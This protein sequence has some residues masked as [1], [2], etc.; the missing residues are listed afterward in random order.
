MTKITEHIQKQ[1]M[2]ALI[3]LFQLDC[4]MFGDQI[5][6]LVSGDFG[7]TAHQVTFG[8]IKYYP[9]PI[10]ADGF[11]LAGQGTL[12]KP[13]FV[14]ANVGNIFTSMVLANRGLIGAELTRIRTF[15]KFLDNGADPDPTATLASDV[16]RLTRKV[17]HT[18][19][20]IQWELSAAMDQAG[21]ELPGR[22]VARDYCDHVYRSWNTAAGAFDYS[23]CTC[24]YVG[25]SYFDEYDNPTTADKDVCGKRLSSCKLRFGATAEL[26][27]RGFPGVATVK[28][29]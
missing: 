18:R 26:P 16:Y 24:P 8:G 10:K 4:T 19:K 29:R 22:I 15:S 11:E 6:Y 1:N 27:F 3:E 14:V 17:K 9:H 7:S 28:V 25:G 5:Y 2:G 12:P 23:G 21:S 13:N 20:E